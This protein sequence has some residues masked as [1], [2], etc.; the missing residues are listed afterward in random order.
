M[1]DQEQIHQCDDFTEE[2]LTIAVKTSKVSVKRFLFSKVLVFTL[3]WFAS[4]CQVG[5]FPEVTVKLRRYE[6]LEKPV[7]TL[8]FCAGVM[9]LI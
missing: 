5:G 3:I 4:W 6:S 2:G 7:L 8:G 1:V 9:L